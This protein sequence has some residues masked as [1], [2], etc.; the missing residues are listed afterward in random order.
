MIKGRGQGGVEDRKGGGGRGKQGWRVRVL[1]QLWA[2]SPLSEW[3]VWRARSPHPRGFRG[4]AEGRLQRK[5]R[6]PPHLHASLFP[7]QHP[8]QIYFKPRGPH[9]VGLPG[10]RADVRVLRDADADLTP[11]LPLHFCD[12]VEVPHGD[13]R[14]HLQEGQLERGLGDWEA[15]PQGALERLL[16]P[17]HHP[18]VHLQALVITNS[19]KRE[20]TVGEIVNLMSVDAQRFMDVVP[21][22]NLLWSAPMQ[23]IL[24]M[25]FLWQVT[26]E[27]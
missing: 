1:R 14:C 11:V 6:Q 17:V 4:R 12:G 27:L 23:I 5:G 24:A 10:G 3:G 21:F 2:Q 19:V 15:S 26:P 16:G 8:D 9:L 13:H 22:L 7:L 18:A 25:Y 20:S